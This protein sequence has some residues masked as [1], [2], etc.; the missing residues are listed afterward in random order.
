MQLLDQAQDQAL[1]LS[2]LLASSLL[3]SDLSRCSDQ[4]LAGL[5]STGSLFAPF[6]HACSAASGGTC[7]LRPSFRGFQ[8]SLPQS[9]HLSRLL[10]VSHFPPV[11]A[12]PSPLEPAR[13]STF[14]HLVTVARRRHRELSAET[15]GCRLAAGLQ[16]RPASVASR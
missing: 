8:T 11:A 16:R 7:C 15:G 1:D 4:Q 9:R 5:G 3:R 13:N 6:T 2:W 12:G 14:I 10:L